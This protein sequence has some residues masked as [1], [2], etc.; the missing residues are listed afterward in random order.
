MGGAARLRR[1]VHHV[2]EVAGTAKQE[3]YTNAAALLMPVRCREPFGMVI[4]EAFACGTPAIAFLEG[5]ATEIVIDGHAG[6]EG[7]GLSR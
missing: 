4:V 2:G 5:A 1:R 3:Q 6:P 7:T